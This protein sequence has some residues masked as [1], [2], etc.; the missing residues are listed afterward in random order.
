MAFG[1]VMAVFGHIVRARLLIGL[2]IA[3]VFLA[4]FAL[5]LATNVV[6]SG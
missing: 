1:F 3:I 6:K 5:P 4:T 2:G